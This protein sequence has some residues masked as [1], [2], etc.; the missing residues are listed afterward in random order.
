MHKNDVVVEKI[1]VQDQQKELDKESYEESD[2][3]AVVCGLV[4]VINLKQVAIHILIAHVHNRDEKEIETGAKPVPGNQFAEL[5]REAKDP[6]VGNVIYTYQKHEKQRVRY[7]TNCDDQHLLI[8]IPV[9]VVQLH[10]VPS[11]A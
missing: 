3:A 10:F 5:H 8:H 1:Y 4:I 6:P 2:E 9:G 7:H 11:E